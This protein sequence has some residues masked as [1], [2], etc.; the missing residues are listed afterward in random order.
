MRPR[1]DAAENQKKRCRKVSVSNASMRPR[2][3]A[4][5]NPPAVSFRRL[6]TDRASMRPRPDAAENLLDYSSGR[7]LDTMLQ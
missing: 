4:A 5:E 6:K 2:P 3:D 1:P 7:N